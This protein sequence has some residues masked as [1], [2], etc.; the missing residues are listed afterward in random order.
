MTM[1]DLTPFEVARFRAY[2]AD[3]SAQME[4]DLE[5]Q[6]RRSPGLGRRDKAALQQRVYSCRIVAAMLGHNID[7]KG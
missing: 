7:G 4:T 2:L 6:G 1:T 5:L 3:R